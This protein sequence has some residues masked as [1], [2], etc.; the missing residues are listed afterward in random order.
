MSPQRFGAQRAAAVALL[1]WIA[2]VAFAPAA[3]AQRTSSLG[4]VRLAGAEQCI[5]TQ[6]L[7]Q[8]VEQRVGRAVF[9]SASQA[10]LAIEGR[11]ERAPDA[12]AF[13]VTLVVS[14]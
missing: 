5:A 2:L 6:Q 8:R 10:D 3:R 9:V 4:W 11:V 7:A 1:V 13:V 14:D 12:D